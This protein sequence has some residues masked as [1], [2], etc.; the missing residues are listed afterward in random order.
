[1][2]MVVVVGPFW[3][4]VVA[5]PYHQAEQEGIVQS[6]LGPGSHQRPR[7]EPV[8]TR[9]GVGVVS[10][11]E[12]GVVGWDDQSNPGEPDWG[13]FGLI[14]ERDVGTAVPWW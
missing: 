12:W 2:M 14:S 5:V 7:L 10:N 11:S 1:M 3:I 9:V 8:D 4:L 13:N 6:H